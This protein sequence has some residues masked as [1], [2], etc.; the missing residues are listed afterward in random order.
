MSVANE[1]R[2]L[3]VKDSQDT[4]QKAIISF[5]RSKLIV[6]AAHSFDETRQTS[7]ELPCPSEPC[8]KERLNQAKADTLLTANSFPGELE[9]NIEAL[10]SM[11]VTNRSRSA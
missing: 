9:W 7:A 1:E 11:A 4:L 6:I 8:S 3:K 10:I 2:R 5:G